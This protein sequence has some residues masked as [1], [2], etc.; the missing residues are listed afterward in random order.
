MFFDHTQIKP[1]TAEV[2]LED[3]YEMMHRPWFSSF[4]RQMFRTWLFPE[5]V[6][7][8]SQELLADPNNKSFAD[9]HIKPVSFGAKAHEYVN[10]VYWLYNTHD[11]TRR[12]SANN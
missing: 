1:Y 3:A 5:F 11:V 6:T 10:E 2:K 8:E 4:Y 9:L 7:L 12:E